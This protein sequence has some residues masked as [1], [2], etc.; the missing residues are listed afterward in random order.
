M[1]A[2][3]LMLDT[4]KRYKQTAIRL[5]IIVNCFISRSAHTANTIFNALQAKVKLQVE[6]PHFN[7]SLGQ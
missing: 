3:Q 1:F 5:C 4:H 6:L 7:T 2:L